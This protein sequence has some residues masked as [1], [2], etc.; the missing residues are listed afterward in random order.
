MLVMFL[1]VF[2]DSNGSVFVCG[3]NSFGQLGLGDL[4]PRHIPTKIRFSDLDTKIIQIAAGSYHTVALDSNGVVYTCGSHTVSPL[5][6]TTAKRHIYDCIYICYFHEQKGQLAREPEESKTDAFWFAKMTPLPVVGS[7]YGRRVTW[8]SAAGDATFMK[9][10]VSLISP[11]SLR[12]STVTANLSAISKFIR[13]N[14]FMLFKCYK[15]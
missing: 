8:I 7:K 15:V 13:A 3:S 5:L 11:Q 14:T 9:L 4:S 12:K 10:E 1:S 2:L 6:K